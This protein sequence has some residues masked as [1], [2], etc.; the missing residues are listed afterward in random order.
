MNVETKERFLIVCKGEIM[1]YS[2]T[3]ERMARDQVEF[4]RRACGMNAK[5]LKETTTT[6]LEEVKS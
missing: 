4:L 2:H 3:S 6:T 5:I 1:P